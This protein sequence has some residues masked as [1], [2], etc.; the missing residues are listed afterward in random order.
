MKKIPHQIQLLIISIGI[1]FLLFSPVLFLSHYE[2]SPRIQT[3]TEIIP[4]Y[5]SSFDSTQLKDDSDLLTA[6]FSSEIYTLNSDIF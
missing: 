1:S 2:N 5:S 6:E 4:Q 3:R